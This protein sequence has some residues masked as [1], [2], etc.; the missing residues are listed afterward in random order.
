MMEET[1]NE[2]KLGSNVI[3]LLI[4]HRRPFLMVDAI[5][6]LAFEPEPR[7]EAS[8]Q[9]SA[10]EEV[11]RGHFPGLHLWPGVY[12]IEGLG[13]SCNLLYVLV[14]ILRELG[15]DRE[16]LFKALRNLELGFRLHPGFKADAA[17]RITEG[18]S[19]AAGAI[20][21][22]SSVDLKFLE[23]V[24]AGQRLVYDV[25]LT[26]E[27]GDQLRFESEARVGDRPVARGTLTASCA[28]RL[29]PIGTK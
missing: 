15:G 16:T 22:S 25:R 1:K 13:Q 6:S 11:F 18:L 27:I 29:P 21:V 5:E 3:E 28:F 12:T 24:F 7:L 17:A 2:V 8:R 26:H 9:I 23:P 19:K 14:R 10:N 4:P 20:G